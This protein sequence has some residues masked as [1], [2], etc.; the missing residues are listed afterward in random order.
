MEA[1]KQRVIE[2]LDLQDREIIYIYH[3]IR[4]KLNDEFHNI[5][6]STFNGYEL[7]KMFFHYINK[8]LTFIGGDQIHYP[9]CKKMEMLFKEVDNDL[10][11]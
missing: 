9:D 1:L 2:V 7:T 4:P 3:S 11:K 5:I 8:E 6:I 10:R